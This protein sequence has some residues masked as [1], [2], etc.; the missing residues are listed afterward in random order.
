[1]TRDEFCKYHWEYYLVLEKDFLEIERYVTFDLG[2]NFLYDGQ[3]VTDIGNS[4]CFSNEFIKQYQAICSEVDVILKSICQEINSNSTAKNMK[5]YTNEVLSLPEWA[6]IAKQ[7]VN[8]KD[9]ELQP[10]LSWSNSPY[11]S[12]S[13]WTQYNNVKHGRL[14]NYKKANLKNTINSL[15]ALYALEQYLVKYIGERDQTKDVPNDVSKMF[16]M[17]DFK[18]SDTVIG[19]NQYLLSQKDMEKIWNSKF[20]DD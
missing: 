20:T 5:E 15:A 8:M 18:T 9:V 1:M 17:V 3:P 7:K 16:E 14:S 13:W 12:P 2:D 4:E 19:K 6:N 11:N 10:F